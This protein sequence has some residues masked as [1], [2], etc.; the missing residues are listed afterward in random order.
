MQD[1][2]IIIFFSINLILCL[3]AKEEVEVIVEN[4]WRIYVNF[5]MT[6]GIIKKYFIAI[7]CL[8]LLISK[9]IDFCSSGKKTIAIK[10]NGPLP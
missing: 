9:F 7:I 3:R 10:Q 8:V 4:A 5:W 1:A 2:I 6:T